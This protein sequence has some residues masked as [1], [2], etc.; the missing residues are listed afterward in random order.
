LSGNRFI[1]KKFRSD[2]ALRN[3]AGIDVPEHTHE[4]KT[5]A[6]AGALAKRT[7]FASD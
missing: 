5:G 2:P 4:R 6:G 3:I 7:G 1:G